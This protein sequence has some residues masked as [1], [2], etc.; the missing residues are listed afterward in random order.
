MGQGPERRRP[1]GLRSARLLAV[2]AA[3]WLIFGF[4][5]LSV[6]EG[7]G[8]WLGLPRLPLALFVLWGLLIAVLALLAERAAED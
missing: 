6:F 4:P 1:Q 5:L 8:S 3:G 2:F 7:P